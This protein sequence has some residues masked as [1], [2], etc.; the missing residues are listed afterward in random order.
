MVEPLSGHR[1]PAWRRYLRFWGADSGRDLDDELRF[2]LAARYDEYVAS[3]MSAADARIETERR[4]GDLT[5]V[6]EQCDA[7]DSQ[8]NRE[9]S[10]M[11]I[12]QRIGA[13]LRY[14]SRQLRRNASLTIAAVACLALGI[15]ANTAIFSVVNAVLY[16]PLPYADPSRLVLVGE[17]LP[18]FGTD[19][20]GVISRPEFSDYQR[21]DGRIFAS[22][23]IYEPAELAISGGADYPERV[24]TV[25]MSWNLLAV[26][27]VPPARGRNFVATDGDTAT[28]STV[29]VSD[30]LWH[31]R[32][33]ANPSIIGQRID[34]DGWPATIVGVM[35]ASLQ[36]PLPGIGGQ[37]ADVFVPF[38]FRPSMEFMRGNSY[39]TYFV[40][41]LAS[42]VSLAAAKRA[43]S[44]LAAS[45]PT[46]HPDKYS[47]EWKTVADVFPLRDHAVQ[48]VR[49]PLLIL[50]AAVG[51]V[52][53][54]ACINVSSLMLARAAA[55]E[56][57]ISVRQ[58]LG[59]SF[60]RLVQQ[61]LAESAVLVA[62]GTGS[63]VLIAVWLARLLAEHAP[64]DVLHAYSV[65]VDAR[66][67]AVTGAVAI[68][69]T[70]IFS[71]VPAFGARQN[72]L[73]P[74]LHASTR[75]ST[76]GLARQRAR[77]T[78]VVTQIALALLLST[79]AG[80]MLRSFA[81]AREVNPG[82][83]PRN[84]IAFRTGLPT[85]RYTSSE[86]VVQVEQ[87]LLGALRR[88]PG[89][90]YASATSELPLAA[91]GGS[92]QRFAIS[93]E[94]K[95]LPSIPIAIG[96]IVYDGYFDAMG[97][98]LRDGRGFTPSDVPG[99]LPVAIVNETMAKR[100]FG[101]ESAIGHRIK[102]GSPE[103]PSKW[104][105]I[106][107]VAS[108][109]NQVAVDKAPEPEFYTPATQAATNGVG[110]LRGPG[111]IVRTAGD[112]APIMAAVRRAVRDVDPDLPMVGLKRMTDVVD[113]SM[114]SRYF[115]T[116]LLA[117]FA[118]LALTLASIGIYG[119][120]AYSVVQRTREIGV[121]L[122][123]GAMPHE[124]VRL[125]LAQ[126]TRLAGVGVV[127]GLAAAFGVT[128]LM[129]SLLF[130][131]SPLDAAAFVGSAALL[132]IV[133][134]LASYLPARRAAR[135]DPQVAIR[136]E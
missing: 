80:L 72:S 100:Y 21:L 86:S 93:F 58:A 105:T 76:A 117:G 67:L 35:P 127:I 98:R 131:V 44:D 9:R 78:L 20:F 45:L 134:A 87:R 24:G 130:D 27:G 8:W 28:E 70:V 55:R 49:K 128:R 52:L 10:M 62:I 77:R 83:E 99:G 109:V 3:G 47:H 38:K 54:I 88:I 126:G 66:V 94:G 39:E 46:I 19:N 2:H 115:N 79:A 97:I 60:G 26:L 124:I 101:S 108:D 1:V 18:R 32:F 73:T 37:P 40:G 95:T 91:A 25:H 42:G 81:R 36:F 111:F 106:V 43:A 30:A 89:V 31:R 63:G 136:A 132:L 16:R 50:L 84:A 51:L 59:A 112:P 23:A 120:I 41:R 57:E 103:S 85:A 56:R 116:V 6:R 96:E 11:D 69:T 14:A 15:G 114:A 4:F 107:G 17:G 102:N 123:I 29:I 119:L 13:D 104:L 122:A 113:A 22:S 64:A 53:L 75:G 5:R 135:I 34:V 90:R 71:L 118:L 121:R 82:F 68:V 7:I 65:S 110:F 129:Q 61:F 92:A 133:A 74:S 125:V 48:D 12:V 33:G